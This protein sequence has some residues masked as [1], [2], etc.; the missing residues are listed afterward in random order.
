MLFEKRV[1]D[2]DWDLLEVTCSE[3][4]RVALKF[5]FGG[6]GTRGV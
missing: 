6:T 3:I 4:T 5:P 2:L 1:V